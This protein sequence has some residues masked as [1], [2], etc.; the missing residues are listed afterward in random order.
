MM[1]EH[2]E[3]RPWSVPV[4]VADVPEEGRRVTLHAD[5]KVRAALARLADVLE[6]S[7]LDATFDLARHGKDGLRVTG[8]VDAAVR[9]TCVVSLEPMTSAI[10][11]P[12]DLLFEPPGEAAEADEEAEALTADAAE[13]PEPLIGGQVDLGAVATEFLLLGIDPYPRRPDAHFE[14][15]RAEEEPAD[16]PFAALKGFKAGNKP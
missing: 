9:Q 5:D 8:Q 11:E 12:V 3:T 6:V 13:P 15:P 10:N 1:S 14:P 4:T 2:N 7:E 16:H